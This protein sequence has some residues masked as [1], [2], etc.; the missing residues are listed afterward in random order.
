VGDK[1]E[2]RRKLEKQRERRRSTQRQRRLLRAGLL[3]WKVMAGGEFKMAVPVKRACEHCGAE[4]EPQRTTA[5]FCS[6][7]CRVYAARAKAAAVRDA[8]R[9][10]R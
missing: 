9:R 4:F 5:R 7:K 8:A 2:Q 1:S 10:G 6:T 3:E